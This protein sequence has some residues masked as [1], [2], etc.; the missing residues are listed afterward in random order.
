MTYLYQITRLNNFRS[1][2]LSML[3][4][5]RSLVLTRFGR[6]SYPKLSSFLAITGGCLL[7]KLVDIVILLIDYDELS[8]SDLQFAYQTNVSTTVCSRAASSV[9][10]YF[11]MKGTVVYV[12]AMD[13]SKAFDMIEWS[14]LFG[15][16]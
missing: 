16:L 8:F 15:I 1:V 6:K 3:G 5:F 12:A 11:N 14:E 10:E 4:S 2:D 7:L 13:I 9:I